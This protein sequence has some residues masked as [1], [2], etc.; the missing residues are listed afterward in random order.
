MNFGNKI[1]SARKQKILTVKSFIQLLGIK[2]SPAYITKIE[3]HQEIPEPNL[4]CR[5]AE[6]L[7]LNRNELLEIAKESK[8][9]NFEQTITKKYKQAMEDLND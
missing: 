6:V 2:I 8:I 3:I 1:K 5:M 7:D 4:I 9:R